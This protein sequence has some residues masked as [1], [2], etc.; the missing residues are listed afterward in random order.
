MVGR[1]SCVA[2]VLVQVA[3]MHAEDVIV[4]HVGGLRVTRVESDIIFARGMTL[5]TFL[6]SSTQFHRV[7]RLLLGGWYGSTGRAPGDPS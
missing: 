4:V 5:I 6:S 7:S 3:C 2:C 1:V